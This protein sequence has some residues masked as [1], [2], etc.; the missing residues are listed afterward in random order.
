MITGDLTAALGSA[1]CQRIGE[2]RYGLWF[3]N[4]TRLSVD[5]GVC[6]IGVPNYFYQEWLEKTFGA[7]IQAL[8]SKF[9]RKSVRIVFALDPELFREARPT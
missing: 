7:D 5:A 2:D 1:L 3:Q 9:L 6:A 8:P 4:K